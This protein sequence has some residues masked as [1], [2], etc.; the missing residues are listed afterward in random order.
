M[1]C[2]K[3]SNKT[4]KPQQKSYCRFSLLVNDYRNTKLGLY[5]I[6]VRFYY[7]VAALKLNCFNQTVEEANIQVR[8]VLQNAGC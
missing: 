3:L 1:K 6:K 7:C 8:Y 2:C 4:G 5:F